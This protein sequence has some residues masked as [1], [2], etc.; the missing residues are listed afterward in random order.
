MG[1]GVT[2]T[3]LV[4]IARRWGYDA[5]TIEAAISEGLLP[6]AERHGR[7]QGEGWSWDYPAGTD[8]RLRTLL[9]LRKRGYRGKELRFALWW[10][11]AIPWSPVV[12]AYVATV[13][14]DAPARLRALAQAPTAA[15]TGVRDDDD[16][17]E[18]VTDTDDPAADALAAI[19]VLTEARGRGL[20]AVLAQALALVPPEYVTPLGQVLALTRVWIATAH[21][22][23]PAELGASAR[24]LER[25]VL[26]AGALPDR[27][28]HR[29]A[30]ALAQVLEE[31]AFWERCEEIVRGASGEAYDLAKVLLRDQ[32]PHQPFIGWA[33]A[34]SAALLPRLSNRQ[35]QRLGLMRHPELAIR[36]GMVGA[37]LLVAKTAQESASERQ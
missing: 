7:G 34:V 8:R 27:D 15:A 2:H 22:L 3:A 35:R 9:R 1:K 4:A 32:L 17:A 24:F 26:P 12:A 33:R 31:P 20:D 10:L 14:A 11:G 23:P 19:A 18:G 37:L 30:A 5:G 28:Q 21:R 13:A 36:A 16:A 25:A 6:A 29:I